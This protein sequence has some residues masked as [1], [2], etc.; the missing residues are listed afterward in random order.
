MQSAVVV[1]VFTASG[2]YMPTP[3]LQG[4]VVECVGGGGGG[5]VGQATGA[6]TI[7]GGGGG[8]SGCYSRGSFSAIMVM[9]GVMVTIGAGGAGATSGNTTAPMVTISFG[10]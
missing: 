3:G 4:C 5:G 2:P 10:A 6:G 8:G 7:V 9:G 1:R